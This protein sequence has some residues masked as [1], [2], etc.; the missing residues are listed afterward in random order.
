[1]TGPAEGPPSDGRQAELP[2]GA[3]GEAGPQARGFSIAFGYGGLLVGGVAW[4]VWWGSQHLPARGEDW[5]PDTV[6]AFTTLDLVLLAL[7][8]LACFAV[9]GWLGRKRWE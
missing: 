5:D 2:G 9:A 4:I 1:M 3:P 6:V 8:P 7:L